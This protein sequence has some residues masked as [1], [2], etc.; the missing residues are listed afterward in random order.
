[1]QTYGVVYNGIHF[2][3]WKSWDKRVHIL[4]LDNKYLSQNGFS[5][6]LHLFVFRSVSQIQLLLPPKLSDT[7]ADKH[8]IVFNFYKQKK[9]IWLFPWIFLSF[10][11]LILCAAHF[12][13]FLWVIYISWLSSNE[14]IAIVFTFFF[15]LVKFITL[16]FLGLLILKVLTFILNDKIYQPLSPYFL[17]FIC[18]QGFPGLFF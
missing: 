10:K 1:M 16:G 3:Y 7:E 5:N 18:N 4:N 9:H 14:N 11:E 15:F 6:R 8:F 13:F 12:Y 17:G 2:L